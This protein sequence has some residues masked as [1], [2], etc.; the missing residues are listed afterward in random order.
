MKKGLAVIVGSML[1][2]TY[3]FACGCS[4]QSSCGQ[5]HMMKKQDSCSHNYH[6]QMMKKKGSCNTNYNSD[7]MMMKKFKM[8]MMQH[9]KMMK[10]HEMM[11]KKFEMMMN[12]SQKKQ[13]TQKKMQ[14]MKKV[15]PQN[16][17]KNN[18]GIT[19]NEEADQTD[20][21]LIEGNLE[22]NDFKN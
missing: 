11:M 4:C 10:Q 18:V 13:K 15:K 19:A 16:I 6:K 8:M 1:L 22:N 2:S 9:H 20:P 7:Q 5:G 21:T 17:D 14:M 3:A 12:N